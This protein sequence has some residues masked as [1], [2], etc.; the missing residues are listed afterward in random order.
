MFSSQPE[1]VKRKKRKDIK[2]WYETSNHFKFICLF[3]LKFRRKLKHSE[4]LMLLSDMH[5]TLA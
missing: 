5:E 2:S 4:R 1:N 3:H